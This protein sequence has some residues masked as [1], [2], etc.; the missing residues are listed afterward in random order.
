MS[1]LR[2]ALFIIPLIVL[3]GFLAGQVTGSA[4][5][6]R[7]FQAL[8]KPAAQPPNWA[9]PVAW[10]LLYILIGLAFSMILNARGAPLRG[11]AII[12][13]LVQFALNLAWSPLFF[14]MH[15]VSSAFWLLVVMFAAA[16]LTTLVF[17]RIRKAAA[18]LMVPYLA[19]LCFAAILNKQ[20]DDLNPD[21]ETLV[22]PAA[23]TQI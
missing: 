2:W 20:I 4:E 11:L 10:T 6:N 22:V 12:L 5:E 1:L 9:F 15:Q 7:W 13:F 21:A 16:F 23:S 3:L 17:G 19:W 8:V 18:W 14:G